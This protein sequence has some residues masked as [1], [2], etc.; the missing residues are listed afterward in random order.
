MEFNIIEMG[1]VIST[2][3]VAA[4]G[5]Y[6]HGTIITARS[7]TAGRGQRGNRWESASGENLMFSLVVRPA[8]IPPDRQFIISMMASLAA[9]DALRGTGVDCM[10]KWPNDLYV[11]DRKIGGILIEHSVMGMQLTS[12]IIGIGINVGQTAFDSSLPNPTSVMLETGDSRI[13]SRQ[14]LGNFCD[15]F[16]VRYGEDS[17][18][19]Y[20]DYM[21]RLWRGTGIHMFRTEDEGEFAASV[22]RIDPATGVLTLSLEDG[23]KRDF[24]FKEV[25][26]VL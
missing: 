22:A 26:F 4:A 17:H 2:N 25:E 24:R 7:Q 9:S 16:A 15:A 13:V 23:T 19:L 5:G 21:A 1:K 20:E 8:H 10:L 3:D 6:P 18:R 12:S 14:V 11:A